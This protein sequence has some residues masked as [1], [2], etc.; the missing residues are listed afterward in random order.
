VLD[1]PIP[2]FTFREP[3]DETALIPVPPVTPLPI[4]PCAIERDAEPRAP[5]RS[6]A[7]S[8]LLFI[9]FDFLVNKKPVRLKARFAL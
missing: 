5:M 2:T 9:H 4:N 1:T 8:S 7:F 6:S 3:L